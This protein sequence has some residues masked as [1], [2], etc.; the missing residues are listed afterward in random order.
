MLWYEYLM[1]RINSQIME[2]TND[3]TKN[4][5]NDPIERLTF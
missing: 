3:H 1:S 4:G 2:M 5:K